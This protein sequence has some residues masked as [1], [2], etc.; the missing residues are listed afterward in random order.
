VLAEKLSQLNTND[1][2]LVVITNRGQK[3]WPDTESD[4]FSTDHWR[5]RFQT[6]GDGLNPG[7]SIENAE[8]VSL[9]QRAHESGFDFIKLENL[10]RFD[11]K[12]GY[13]L[14]QGQV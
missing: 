5:C 9:L 11:G 4:A 6:P 14:A 13:S 7:K 2:Q 8:I 3:A 10:Y 12:L 1:L